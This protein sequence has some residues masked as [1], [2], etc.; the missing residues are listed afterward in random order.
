MSHFPG[1]ESGANPTPWRTSQKQA[2]PWIPHTPPCLEW[3]PWHLHVRAE[4][5]QADRI[6]QFSPNS[7]ITLIMLSVQVLKAF[8]RAAAPKHSHSPKKCFQE[9]HHLSALIFPIIPMVGYGSWGPGK[10]NCRFQ[11]PLRS[12]PTAMQ[13][14]HGV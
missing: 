1:R 8:H 7:I 6:I 11:T 10:L 12:S 5:F 9:Q 13:A 14:H 2:L 3:L 4:L